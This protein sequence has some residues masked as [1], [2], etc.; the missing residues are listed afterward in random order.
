MATLREPEEIH[1]VP[2]NTYREGLLGRRYHDPGLLPPQPGPVGLSHTLRR[3]ASASD[4]TR[5][6][7]RSSVHAR[8]HRNTQLHAQRPRDPMIVAKLGLP[9]SESAL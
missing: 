1:H 7:L 8:L 4:M 5:D 2:V 6:F 3:I 9:F